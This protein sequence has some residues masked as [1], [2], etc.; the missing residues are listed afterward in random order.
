MF[1]TEMEQVVQWEKKKDYK[2]GLIM[3]TVSCCAAIYCSV[4]VKQGSA[5]YRKE[6]KVLA[7]LVVAES[8]EM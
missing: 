1:S 2:W 8:M 5:G 3:L 6:K 7:S 4:S